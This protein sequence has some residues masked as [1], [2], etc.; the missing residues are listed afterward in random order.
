M[1]GVKHYVECHCVIPQYGKSKKP[2]YYKFKAFSEIDNG[3]NVKCKFLQCPNC[4]VVHK[5]IDLCKSEI[6]IGTE[7]SP[8]VTTMIDIKLSLPENLVEL[9]EKHNLS[10]ADYEHLEFIIREKKW[11]DYIVLVKEEN[12]EKIEGKILKFSSEGKPRV[13]PFWTQVI[14]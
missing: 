5:V 8:V 14:I 9:L 13:E 11:E 4:N 7:N 12:K 10:I 3:N 6:M 1:N 2:L